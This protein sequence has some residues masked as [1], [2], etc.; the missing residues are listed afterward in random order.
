MPGPVERLRAVPEAIREFLRRRPVYAALVLLPTLLIALYYLLWCS[1]RYVSHARL[2]VERDS[3]VPAAPVDLGILALGSNQTGMDAQLV[4]T[5][6]ESPSM[7]DYL[8]REIGLRAHYSD[9]ARDLFSRLDAGASHESF[10]SFYLDH[11]RVEL[12]EDS[13]ALNIEVEGYDPA[14]AQRF[15]AT[16]VRRA[17]EFVNNIGQT[18]AREQLSFVKAEVEGANRRLQT[19]AGVM[20]EMQN[21]NQLLSPEQET[22]AVSQIIGGLQQELAR[23][24]T[25]LSALTSYL[26]SSAQEV[27]AMRNKIAAIERQI[28]RERGKQ[29][30]ADGGDA[31]LNDLLLQFQEQQLNV[32]IATDLYQTGL[33]SLE[34]A[35]LDASRKVKYLVLVSPP[36]LPEASLRPQRLYNTASVFVVLNL[37]YLL[38]HLLIL[39]VKDHKE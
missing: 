8:D 29:V 2:I 36:T 13:M 18:L 31:S 9:P 1:D 19:E 7:A 28:E 23:S 10:V 22:M 32:Q 21:R 5:F 27:I 35:R 30:S 38:G 6:V 11:I 33:K 34:V 3:S 17:E 20:R 12:D 4:K 14:Y 39:S 16:V 24:R 25:E 37:I 15:A 26:S